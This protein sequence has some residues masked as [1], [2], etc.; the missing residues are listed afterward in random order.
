MFFGVVHMKAFRARLNDSLQ[1]AGV[2]TLGTE[3]PSTEVETEMTIAFEHHNPL[4][5]EADSRTETAIMR[6][7]G[8]LDTVTVGA[9][10]EAAVPGQT[11]HVLAK[12]VEKS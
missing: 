5:G 9:L 1:T 12:R 7:I 3:I 10:V 8:R 2:S 11:G 4:R 6:D